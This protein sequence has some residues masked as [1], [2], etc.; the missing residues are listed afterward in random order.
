MKLNFRENEEGAEETPSGREKVSY[1]IALRP[2]NVSYIDALKALDDINNYGIYAANL[3]NTSS[4][5]TKAL[6]DHFGPSIPVRKKSLE[7]QRGAPFP[8]KTKAAIDAFT[9]EWREKQGTNKIKILQYEVS[10]GKLIVFPVSKNPEK[11]VTKKIIDTVMKSAGI[12]YKLIDLERIDEN[13]T[14]VAR[15]VKE[16]LNKIA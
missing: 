15:L 7:K 2:E 11:N 12:E 16:V 6:E 3:R 14:R 9:K 13:T 4:S 10:P 8:P 1:D 5:L